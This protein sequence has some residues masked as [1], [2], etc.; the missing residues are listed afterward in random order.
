MNW[1]KFLESKSIDN[2]FP[3]LETQIE[4]IINSENSTNILE[5]LRF[6]N[7]INIQSSIIF[8]SEFYINILQSLGG[9]A[10]KIFD[11]P[12]IFIPLNDVIAIEILNYFLSNSLMLSSLLM[13]K[14]KIKNEYLK[15]I[16]DTISI[17]IGETDISNLS[18]NWQKLYFT[19]SWAEKFIKNRD[20][21]V[22]GSENF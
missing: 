17:S 4:K 22:F 8:T 18:K 15:K 16:F 1:F 13:I 20:S 11:Y 9:D 14:D 19:S 6:L 21:I 12:K 3:N 10:L 7:S 5:I 2:L